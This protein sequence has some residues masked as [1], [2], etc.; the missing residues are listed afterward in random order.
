MTDNFNFKGHRTIL[1]IGVMVMLILILP[2]ISAFEFD[3]VKSYDTNLKKATINNAFGLGGEILSATLNSEQ[4]VKVGAG[5]QNVFNITLNPKEDYNNIINS[6]SFRDLKADRSVNREIDLYYWNEKEVTN[7]VPVYSD[8]SLGN[9]TTIEKANVTYKEQGV[10]RVGE[11]LP[12][13]NNVKINEEIIIG[14]FTNVQIGD[15][16]DWIPNIAGVNINEWAVWSHDLNTNL[17]YYF[18]NDELNAT[19]N[20]IENSITGTDDKVVVGNGN[21]IQ[22]GIIGNS[23]RYGNLTAEADTGNYSAITSAINLNN[24]WSYNAWLYTSNAL[25]DAPNDNLFNY[26]TSALGAGTDKIQI[27][28]TN[29]PTTCYGAFFR[30]T[31][32]TLFCA[33]M[34]TPF[35]TNEW[36]MFSMSY[37]NQTQNVTF[38]LNGTLDAYEIIDANIDFTSVY[39]NSPSFSTNNLGFQIDEEGLW[40]GRVINQTEITQLY[41]GGDGISYFEGLTLSL[42][43]PE[44]DT[45]YLTKVLNFSANVVDPNLIGVTNVTFLINDTVNQTNSSGFVGFYNFST[46]ITYGNYNWSVIVYDDLINIYTS[47]T[48]TFDVV[49]L[50]KTAE[51]FVASTTSGATNVFNIS[52]ETDGTEITVAYINYNNTN[53]VGTISSDGNNYVLS[54]N[55]VAPPLSTT[56]NISFF[57]NITMSDGYNF[58]TAS[59]NQSVSPIV[60]NAT[61]TGMTTLFNFTLADEINQLV[62]NGA[63]NVTSF[64]FDLDLYSSDR[65]SLLEEYFAESLSTNPSAICINNNLSGGESYSLDLQ[66]QY[67]A[68]S[69][70]TELYHIERKVINSTTL[71]QN[72]T[73]YDLNSSLT[74]NFRL[75]ARDTSYLPVDN[76]LIKI[77]RK[78]IENGTFLT[79]E[80]PKTDEKGIT[81]ASLQTK[82]V[83]YNFYI[84]QAGVLISTFT[85][86]LAICQTPLVSQC[87]I[88]FNAFQ[89]SITLPDFEEG[90][91]F[92]FTLGYNETSK[93]VSSQFVI[94]SGS[95]SAVVLTVT[96]EDSLGTS[97][98]SDTLTSASGTLTCTVPSSFGNSTVI[99]KITKDSVE[100]GKGSIKLD[101]DPSD[102]FGPILI[103]LSVMVFLTLLG[104][105]MSDSPVIT[106]LFLFVGVILLFS[107]NLVKNTGFIGATATILFLAIAIILI[108]I[109][110]ARRNNG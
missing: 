40:L 42:S 11:W 22:T 44:D 41:N 107:M 19:S 13:D 100:Q 62:L 8:Y 31:N 61:C 86:V 29:A 17:E 95:P 74:Q 80:I 84:Y 7:Y 55:V 109:K 26:V 45:T 20:G 98:C 59:Q 81:S 46:V 43:L 89:T 5:Y 76:A 99:A 60:I 35:Q 1:L 30:L 67:G 4:D 51:S 97:I 71:H 70:S 50:N 69:Y 2:I 6:F 75:L 49:R 101:Q 88:D 34:T 24:S 48:R 108:I 64:K 54:K 72:I 91:D 33:D 90:D 58:A 21:T 85:N 102:I 106:G 73:L 47:D 38:Y 23:I 103:I 18:T 78:Y 9:G 10:K 96:K 79:T 16:I 110:A 83:I 39:W 25:P 14:G 66:V 53:V 3:N 57:W 82:D 15:R 105:G 28:Y 12:F 37:N 32:G 94:P 65:T 92:N 93:V 87:E 36:T 63:G 104:I 77:D 68:T 56:Q 27:G 52:Y